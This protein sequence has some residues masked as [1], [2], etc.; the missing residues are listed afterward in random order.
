MDRYRSIAAL[1]SADR[2]EA[3]VGLRVVDS[4]LLVTRS[5][6]ARRRGNP[7]LQKMNGLSFRMIE[8]AVSDSTARA[9]P[10]RLARTNDRARA[11]AVLVLERAFEDVSDDLHVAMPV[12]GKPCGRAH[13]I[14]IDD[15]QRAKSHL[16]LIVVIAE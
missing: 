15:P 16:L 14:L 13:A 5:D 11:E 1:G 4:F 2:C 6:A 12:R 3:A 9:H 7:D 8:F 10:L